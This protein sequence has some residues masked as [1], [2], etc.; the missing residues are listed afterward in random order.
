M[1][2]MQKALLTAL[3]IL[4]CGVAL[5]AQWPKFSGAG[6]P[7]DA[8]GKVIMDAPAPKTPDGHPDLSGTWMRAESGPPRGTGPGRGGARAG[9]PARGGAPPAGDAAPAGRPG[10]PPPAGTAPGGNS[11]A[12][13]SGGRGG[14][15]LEPPTERFPYDASG[16]PV[17]TFFE[18][19][20]N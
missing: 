2:R 15:Q 1:A 16:P 20:G 12:A 9:G 4:V 19:G 8:Q 5:F 7:R 10:G 13:F 17:A 3:G 11:N 6:V 18:A 14:V